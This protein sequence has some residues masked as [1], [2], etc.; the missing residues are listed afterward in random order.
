M[1]I[2]ANEVS[3]S[4]EELFSKYTHTYT[5]THTHTHIYIYIYMSIQKTLFFIS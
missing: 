1:N 3:M 5:H 2:V 4:C